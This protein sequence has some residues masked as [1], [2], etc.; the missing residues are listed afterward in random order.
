MLPDDEAR[1]LVACAACGDLVAGR[2]GG[3][4]RAGQ[5]RGDRGEVDLVG[6][7]DRGAEHLAAES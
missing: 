3:A 2:G 6:L 1:R 4:G 7:G 5:G